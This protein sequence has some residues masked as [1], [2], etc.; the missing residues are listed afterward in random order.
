M[1]DAFD[2]VWWGTSTGMRIG[3]LGFV[4]A[5]VGVLL[6]FSFGY[7]PSNPLSYVAYGIVAC[8]VCVGFYGVING[9]VEFVRGMRRKE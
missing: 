3:F 7:G 8:G 5:A 2:R 1:G 4:V 6:G 9:F